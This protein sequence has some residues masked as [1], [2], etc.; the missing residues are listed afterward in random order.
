MDTVLPNKGMEVVVVVILTEAQ[1][2]A[3]KTQEKNE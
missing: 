1:V 3:T 2:K